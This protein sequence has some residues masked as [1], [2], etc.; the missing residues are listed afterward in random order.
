MDFA[1]IEQAELWSQLAQTWLEMEERFTSVSEL[2]GRLAMDRLELQA[3]QQVL[4]IGCGTGMTTLE[5]ASRVG[6]DG[7]AVGLDIT[8]EMLVKAR[9]RAAGSGAVNATFVHG[10][11]QVH[12][13]GAGR[14]DAAYSRFGH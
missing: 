6:P 9:E 2:P 3:G 14:F 11:A 8:S 7:S 12:D 10:D 1:N 5:L 4:D 13:L